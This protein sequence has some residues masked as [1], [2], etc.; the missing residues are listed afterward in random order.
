M[1]N[2]L[3]YKKFK[4]G[5]LNCHFLKWWRHLYT[6]DFEVYK[7]FE[8]YIKGH[9]A[10]SAVDTP[11]EQTEHEM[12]RLEAK[13]GRRKKCLGWMRVCNT[14]LLAAAYNLL[15]SMQVL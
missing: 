6:L 10:M 8:V 1:A 12:S 14:S 7:Y 3:F 11:F 5:L 9:S 13:D 2:F 15:S 4:A